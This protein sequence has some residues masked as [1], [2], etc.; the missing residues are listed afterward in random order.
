VSRDEIVIATKGGL[1]QQGG[2]LVRDASPAWLREGVEASLRNLR[3]DY[4]DLYQVHWPDLR[5]PA[6]ETGA[7]LQEL[8][9]EGKVRHVGVSNYDVD[10]LTELRRSVMVDA[11]QP[12]YHLFRQD[13]DADLLPYCADHEIG[14]LV[15]GALAHGLLSGSM[16]P[17]TVFAADDWRSHSP[18]FAGES[19]AANLAVVAELQA[20]AARRGLS[21]PELALAWTLVHPAVGVVLVGA[22]DPDHLHDNVA[23]AD[24][25]LDDDDLWE[26][27]GIMTSAVPVHGPAPEAM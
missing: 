24:V 19:F 4:I 20:F 3:T 23:A 11:V 21:L 1:R 9:E 5:T 12:P 7:V 8:V 14:V 22:R 16:T 26:I 17:D 25:K 6:E 2:G 18:D 27:D 13:I 10:Q 15:Y